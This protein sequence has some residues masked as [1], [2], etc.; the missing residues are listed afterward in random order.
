MLSPLVIHYDPALG[1]N[2]LICGALVATAAIWRV[3]SYG[4]SGL[5]ITNVFSTAD[6]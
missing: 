4:R 3:S 1:W 6:T 5:S 2:P